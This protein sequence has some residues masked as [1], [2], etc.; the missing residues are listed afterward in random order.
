MNL[1]FDPRR[2]RLTL[3]GA[4][5]LWE[6]YFFVRSETSRGYRLF[7]FANGEKVWLTNDAENQLCRTKKRKP[8]P[9]GADLLAADVPPRQELM[10]FGRSFHGKLS[11]DQVGDMSTETSFGILGRSVGA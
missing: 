8:F 1:K 5:A 10:C 7:R 9:V 11:A 3:D 6:A 4:V 2:R